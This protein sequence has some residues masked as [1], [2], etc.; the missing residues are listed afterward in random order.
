MIQT[1]PVAIGFGDSTGKIFE[2]NESFYRLTGYTPEE[3][4]ASKL[5]WNQLTAPEYAE[6]DSQIMTTLAATGSA[7]PYEKEY[8]RKDGSRIPLLLSVSK[9]PGR[10]EHI[11][12]IV[13]ITERKAAEQE[14][15]R[16]LSEVREE[17][18]RLSA[19]VNSIQDEVWFADIEK[20]FTLANPSALR[21]FGLNSMATI[22]VRGFA[23]SLDV[24]RSD[25]TSRPVEEA[26]PLRALQ[27]EVV[28]NQEEIIRVPRTGELRVRQVSAAPVKDTKDR[29]IGSVSVVRD[30]TERK[31]AE[32]ALRNSRDRLEKRV[33]E[34]TAELLKASL[35]S[36]SLIEASLDPLVTISADGRV[37]DV[38][39]A[40]ELVTGVPRDQ[41]IGTD[42]SDYFT[43][44]EK[45]KEG[46]K[47]VFSEG[48]VR[49]YPLAIRHFSGS[50]I[51]VLYNA[52]LYKN[53]AGEVQGIFAAARDI[54]E[55]K[56]AEE[57]VR[58][59]ENRLRLL[60]SQ[61][62]VAQEK[63][64]RRVAQEI[65]D[66]LGA[67]LAA[68]K[69]KIETTLN[70]LG[71]TDPQTTEALKS[72]IPIIQGTIDEARRIQLALRPSI[73]DDLGLLATV[74]WFCRQYESTYSAIRV[75]Q[76]I[77]IEEHE[78]SDSLKTVIFRVLQEAMNNIAKHSQAT[79][80][81]LALRKTDYAIQLVVQDNGHGF[82]M[83]DILSRKRTGR[84]L[85]LDSMR[86]RCELAGGS[87][88]IEST[89]S[90]TVIQASWPL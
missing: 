71:D 9:F 26:P 1:S 90:G 61:L 78:V 89:A 72:I 40:T 70:Q 29:I 62:L 35:Y 27:G 42:F 38:N 15:E 85:G 52:T 86:E 81:L 8:I 12:F 68:A 34:R 36:R 16:L 14:R 54:T 43:E 51:E 75:K 83:E 53:E 67:S 22:D 11:A 46:Y 69:Y 37:M 5:G 82:V 76:E 60:S 6:L 2:A 50:V 23:E 21:E 28:T 88:T 3:I 74:G 17:K 13:D 63:E 87:F 49:D 65:H 66:S 84:G 39:R 47:R 79:R 31:L 18:D 80:V 57:A 19:L 73:L 77:N 25:G 44:P 59:S 7:G 30:I 48:S 45:A 41:L 58:E 10:D 32:E 4:Q 24:Y 33:E 20:N 55:R 64:R 56:R